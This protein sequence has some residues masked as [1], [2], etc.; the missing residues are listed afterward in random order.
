MTNE[1]PDDDPLLNPDFHARR[2]LYLDDWATI[3]EPHNV[4]A[5]QMVEHSVSYGSTALQASYLLNGGAL[6]ALPALLTSLTSAGAAQIAIAAIPFVV[7]IASTGVASLAAY[8]NFQ[9]QAA[10]YWDD[11]DSAG[12]QLRR[13]YNRAAISLTDGKRRK[14]FTNLVVVSFYVG[15]VAAVLALGSFVYG[16]YQFLDLAHTH[17]SVKIVPSVSMKSA[18]ETPPAPLRAIQVPAAARPAP[19]QTGSRPP[20]TPTAPLPESAPVRT[21][22]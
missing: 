8:L 5:R 11:Y 19:M 9:W 13:F 3:V 6:A 21:K 17:G 1:S 7:G 20:E 10:V 16:C 22:P 14:R 15:V 12:R 4:S 2:S 18:A